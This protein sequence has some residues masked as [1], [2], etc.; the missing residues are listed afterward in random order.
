MKKYYD[1]EKNVSVR[2]VVQKLK[3]LIDF[4]W[5]FVPSAPYNAIQ[6][7]PSFNYFDATELMIGPS[8]LEKCCR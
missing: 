8:N 5:V 7:I 2:R 6:I 3:P 1:S 4:D